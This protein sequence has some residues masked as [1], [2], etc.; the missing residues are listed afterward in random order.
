MA[1]PASGTPNPNSVP[2][3][4]PSE[5]TR[6]GHREAWHADT[7]RFMANYVQPG[8]I[9]AEIGVFWAHFAEVLA[10]EFKP[11]KLFLV[12]PWHKLHGE[13]YPSWGRYTNFG[14]LTTAE[15]LDRA[16]DLEKQ[17][18]G[19]VEVRV[20]YGADFL[21]A[22]PDAHFDWV[23]LDA[24]HAYADVK[25]DLTAILPKIRSGGVIMGDDYFTDPA[26]Q[27]A[28]VKRAVDEFAVERNLDLVFEKRNQFIL[29]LP[30]NPA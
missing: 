7:R 2:F 30:Q 25:A 4:D 17:Y 8:G 5:F 22:M 28:G 23:Y 1:A 29:R 27:H 10:A 9:G 24:H 21:Q 16:R 11:A 19:V 6:K 18:P 3:A 15:T 14:K 13:F 20:E 12:D 26:S